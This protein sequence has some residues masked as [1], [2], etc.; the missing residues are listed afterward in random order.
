MDPT[1]IEHKNINI[2]KIFIAKWPFSA[3]CY[4]WCISYLCYA[5]TGS[6]EVEQT[7]RLNSSLALF[8]TTTLH[9]GV[10]YPIMHI[11]QLAWH[12]IAPPDREQFS[13]EDSR[14]NEEI[15]H[16]NPCHCCRS[17]SGVLICWG[18]LW[19]LKS[20]YDQ[21]RSRSGGTNQMASPSAW[22]WVIASVSVES[23]CR[24][25]C[26][27]FHEYLK[28]PPNQLYRVWVNAS[29]R[30]INLSSF[31]C[32][33]YASSINSHEPVPPEA[34]I[35]AALPAPCFTQSCASELLREA[36]LLLPAILVHTEPRIGPLF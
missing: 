17:N 11:S 31:C 23:F 19:W 15:Q 28:A 33:F 34:V 27:I 6:C 3:F 13:V 26:A 35:A 32:C 12:N 1:V 25:T 4:H 20:G 30:H 5:C 7:K 16:C 36:F 29:G 2:K 21:D 14:I 10:T 22:D 8:P 24:V 9:H 18:R